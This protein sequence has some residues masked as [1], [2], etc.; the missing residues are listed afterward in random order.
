MTDKEKTEVRM[1]LTAPQLRILSAPHRFKIVNAGRRFGKSFMSGAA[2]LSQIPRAGS[3]IWYVAPTWDMA[4]KAMWDVWLPTYIPKNW[5]ADVNKMDKTYR[6]I[7]GSILYVLSADNPEH[8]RGSSLDLLVM[9]E[10]AFIKD[11]VWDIVRPALADKEGDALLISTPKGYNWFYDMYQSA[12]DDPD[13]ASFQ[14]TTIEGGNVS[15][16]EIEISRRSMSPKMFQQEYLASFENLSSRVYDMY[17]RKENS[18]PLDES[19]GKG[20]TDVHVGIDFNVNPM[21]AAIAVKERDDVYFFDEIVEP[22][23]NTQILCNRIRRKFPE[24][25]VFVYPDPTCRKRQTSA[26]V[27]ETDY[28]IL[29]RN[30]FHVCCPKAPY[31]SRDKYNAVNTAFLNAK[32][33]RH[34]FIA[35]G[36]CPN[37]KKALDGYSYREDG[38]DTDKSGGLDHISDAAA[39]LICYLKPIR[40]AWGL[41]RP[42]VYG[43]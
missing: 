24:C 17:D 40:K 31:S 14:Y 21:T 20:R 34:C 36:R 43:Y 30:R 27:G 18:V 13:W 5:I 37:L 33:E 35:E 6:F 23:S 1:T 7:N 4:K 9:D 32:G 12:Q 29:R 22:N 10:C 16:K 25:D 8:L 28:E 11:G 39:Y 41:N 2:I 26:A 15:E 42:R 19:W 38:E 3:I